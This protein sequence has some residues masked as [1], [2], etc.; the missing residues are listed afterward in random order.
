MCRE[1]NSVVFERTD[2]SA[3]VSYGD[4]IL[5]EGLTKQKHD[6]FDVGHLAGGK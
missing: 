5:R 1:N 6:L 2:K 4:A 3:A